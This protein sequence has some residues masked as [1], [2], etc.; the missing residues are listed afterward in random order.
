MSRRSQTRHVLSLSTPRS[1][2]QLTTF[3]R[4]THNVLP[5]N[6]QRSTIRYTKFYH[7]PRHILHHATSYQSTSRLLT[8]LHFRSRISSAHRFCSVPLT[9]CAQFRSPILLSSAHRFCSPSLTESA[10]FRSRTLTYPATNTQTSNEHSR[11]LNEHSSFQPQVPHSTR[12]RR[13]H[14]LLSFSLGSV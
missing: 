6:P 13:K 5:L 7:T 1:S 14:N 3:F 12:S 9:D 8:T 11:P 2:A 4:P 10:H